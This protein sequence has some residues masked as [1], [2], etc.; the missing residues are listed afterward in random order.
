MYALTIKQ[1][2]AEAIA[3]HGKD[4]TVGKSSFAIGVWRGS[5]VSRRQVELA[6]LGSEVQA[7]VFAVED[8]TALNWYYPT[9]DLVILE[10]RLMDL[11]GLKA[12]RDRAV[13]A[14]YRAAA[15]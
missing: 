4:A 2:W 14:Y 6:R 5:R 7:A 3:R 10:S 11:R 8:A 15:R 1:P 12:E 13:D 9:S